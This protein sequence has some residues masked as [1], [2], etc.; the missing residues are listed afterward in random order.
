MIFVLSIAALF[1][2]ISIY[3][4]F[5]AEG[6]QRALLNLKREFSSTKKENKS[7]I[8]SMALVAKRH[9]DFAKH[10]LQKMKE[11]QTLEAE[12]IEVITPFVNNYSIIFREC[13][14]GKGKLQTITKKCYESYDAEGF[15]RL[16][17]YISKQEPHI[18]RMWSSNNLSGYVSLIEALLLLES[19]EEVKP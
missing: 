15:K 18:K 11:R 17:A 5:R 12:T 19:K 4:Y 1:V 6:L 14:K 7:Y 10:R 8:D 13:L 3:F 9:E 2:G 16:V